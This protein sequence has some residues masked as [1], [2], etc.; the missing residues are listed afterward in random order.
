MTVRNMKY[1]KMAV[2][3]LLIT[4]VSAGSIG[5]AYAAQ[6]PGP[7][8]ETEST[9]QEVVVQPVGTQET[10][11][12]EEAAMLNDNVIT[13]EEID[14]IVIYRNPTYLVYTDNI[15]SSMGDVKSALREDLDN[16]VMQLDQLDTSMLGAGVV[17]KQ[18]QDTIS[19]L[20]TQIKML[21]YK[22]ANL[23][24]S[25]FGSMRDQLESAIKTMLISYK[26][27][28]ANK[29]LLEQQIALY[30]SMYNT[31][32]DMVTQGLATQTEAD[33]YKN[34]RDSAKANLG[35]LESGMRQLKGNILAQCGY[36]QT[37]DV[38]IADLPPAD[39]NFLA[40][41]DIDADRNTAVNGNAA[42]RQAA[43]V[44]GYKGDVFKY[45]DANENR[46]EGNAVSAFDDIVTELQKQTLITEA[47]DTTLR[48]NEIL[49][50]S[51]EQKYSLGLVSR[52]EYAG[53]K[54][55][56]MSSLATSKA[57]DLNLHQAILNYY[58]AVRGIMTVES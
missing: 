46:V 34:S 22:E 43:S 10:L 35:K 39:R 31:T 1:L 8:S 6:G 58:Y 27:L 12:P 50:N 14:N 53:L 28:E 17:R 52:S 15:K 47:S 36:E 11:S 18:L 45:R 16:V 2:L 3:G 23:T 40:L 20:N 54:L 26:S 29:E 48:K 51:A 56:Y 57:N 30:E 4:S 7:E 5:M 13:W 44:S 33:S 49:S 9:A 41:R 37:D 42:M 25:S 38:S 55:Q 21:S 32:L 19:S 24:K